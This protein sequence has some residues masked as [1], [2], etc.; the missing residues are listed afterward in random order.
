MNMDAS[1]KEEVM[2][3]GNERGLSLRESAEIVRIPLPTLSYWTNTGLIRP[4]ETV[5]EGRGRRHTLSFLNLI[6]I[7]TVDRLRKKGLSMQRLRKAVEALEDQVGGRPLAKLTLLTDG[8]DLFRVVEGDDELAQV[9]RCHD[10][11]GIFA[12]TFGELCKQVAPCMKES[13]GA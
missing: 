13:V 7:L 3:R 9:V 10:D 12:V 4:M 5:G 1:G 11:Q 6:E 2:K 8:H